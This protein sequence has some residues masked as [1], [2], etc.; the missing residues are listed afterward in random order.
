VGTKESDVTGLVTAAALDVAGSFW[1]TM[2]T[3]L[4][5]VALLV[6]VF[7]RELANAAGEPLRRFARGLVAVIAPLLVV[8][9]VSAVTRLAAM[10]QLP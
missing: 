4:A 3:A 5:V 9:A 8:F 6:F 7:A 2:F 1:S 10:I